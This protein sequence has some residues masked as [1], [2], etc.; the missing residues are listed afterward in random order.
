MAMIPEDEIERIKRESDLAAVVRARGIELK[1][2]GGD[3]IGLCPFHE[4]KNPSLHVTPAKRLWRCVSCHATGNVIQFVQ[5]FDGVSFRHAC[6][7]LKS[8]KLSALSGPGTGAP[9]KKSTVPKLENPLAAD[10]DD[11]AALRQVLD[12]YHARLKENPAALAYLQKRG[13]TAEAIATFK[14]GFVDR[15]LGLR[16]PQKNRAEGAVLRERLTRLGVLRQTGH[17]HLRGCV[18][19]PVVAENGEIGTVYGRAIDAPTK[20]ARHLFLT[21]PQRGVFN[22]AA[23]RAPEIILCEGVIDALTF[24]GAGFRNV[25]TCYSAKALSEE[26]L[27]AL[28]AAKVRRV[29]I[30]F[31]RD[32]AG[33]DGA[34]EVAAQLAAYGVECARVLFPPGQDANAY[35]LAVTPSE[36]SLSVLLRSALPMGEL[37]SKPAVSSPEIASAP[38]SLAAKAASEAAAVAR[39]PEVTAPPKEAAR[40]EKP[41][42]S[43]SPMNA[44]DVLKNEPDEIELGL[45]DRRYRV[46][47][48][49]KNTGFESLRVSLRAACGERWHLDTLDLCSARQRDGF[50][51]AAASETG[52]KSELIKR[53]LGKVLGALEEIQEARLKAEAAPKKNEPGMSADEREA[54]LALL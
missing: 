39:A 31:D 26:L 19:F 28:L 50:V 5:R 51:H 43:P 2:Q 10:A 41:A 18:V 6:E 36:K 4:D 35:A 38:S 33:D 15:T 11:Q 46:R 48:L 42:V 7:L 24:W 30:A 53:D 47:G 40:E 44:V 1:P 8:G 32:K 25:T 3:L 27:A 21:G 9:L 16:V 29:L 13:L 34:A 22:P 14:I 45:G 54:A 49:A 17:E 12:Y 37:R 52:L 20:D 23:L